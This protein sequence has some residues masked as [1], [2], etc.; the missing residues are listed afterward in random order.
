MSAGKFEGADD[1][2]AKSCDA[3]DVTAGNIVDAVTNDDAVSG[4]VVSAM[5]VDNVVIDANVL[6]VVAAVEVVGTVLTGVV[7]TV[8]TK[9]VEIALTEAVV[10]SI[11][12]VEDSVSGF[13]SAL[14]GPAKFRR[15]WNS[16]FCLEIKRT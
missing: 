5:A 2:G 12:V 3:S 13:D 16:F 14:S 8:L 9:V 7:E 11:E 4:F 15:F 1:D 10:S 6:S